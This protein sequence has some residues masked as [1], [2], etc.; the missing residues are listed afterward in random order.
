MG[1]RRLVLALWL[2]IVCFASLVEA[3]TSPAFKILINPTGGATW[4]NY[5]LSRDGKVM[6]ANY[7]GFIYLWTPD[8]LK[9]PFGGFTFLGPGH[10]LSSAIGI[11]NDGK[12]VISSH[13]GDDG[14][15]SPALWRQADG[16]IDLG[17]PKNGCVEDGQWGSGYDVSGDGTKA[18]GL[19]WYCPGAEAFWW[20]RQAGMRSLG[21]PTGV[22]GS[23]R[24]SAISAD[25]TMIVGF[26]ED[27]RYGYRRPVRWFSGRTEWFAGFHTPGEAT[28]VS[29]NGSRIVG[30]AAIGFS[31][32]AFYYTDA[33]G[34][35]S[36]GTI[37]GNEFDQSFANAVADN[38]MT[39]G[40]SG[41]PFG[42]GIQ[43]FIW[44]PRM[45][46]R[47]LQKYLQERGVLIPSGITLTS[48]LD[49]SADGSTIVGV[50]QDASYNQGG[51]MVRLR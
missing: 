35:V 28:A 24:A 46:M 33:G 41:D 22:G 19:A 26:S 2:A 43:A 37:S 13:V 12:T 7:G 14:N 6:A 31:A 4:E 45:K 9:F 42:G 50:W 16:W 38:G 10:F 11:S 17:H 21:H 40:W 39:V 18:V 47:S 3:Q 32:Y 51:W 34:L 48:A 1:S 8:T 49:I 20:T 15:V 30:Q 44:T 5:A 36:L 27:P 25:G 29:S 23:S